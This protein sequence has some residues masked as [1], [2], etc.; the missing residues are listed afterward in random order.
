MGKKAY[1]AKPKMKVAAQ[2]KIEENKEEEKLKL[3][4]SKTLFRDI[5]FTM[6]FV[7]AVCMLVI[8]GSYSVFSTLNKS[9]D[10]NSITVGTL[11]VDFLK[12]SKNVLN[13]NGAYPISDIEGQKQD[14]YSFKITNS[15]TLNAS[16]KI[17]IV[18]D[19][20]MILEDG[21][22][23]NLLGHNEIKVSINNSIPF[24]L[25]EKKDFNYVI[26][27]NILAPNETRQYQIRI[28]IKDSAGNEVLKKHYHGKVVVDS[29]NLNTD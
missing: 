1:R 21:C 4:F 13:L 24:I 12:N 27:E 16:Y 23:N 10:Y 11:K 7:F 25:E 8:G 3:I 18:D 22:S 2:N 26:E 9:D 20:D 6:F 28:W 19:A 17:K 15:G 14:A 5:K 29:V